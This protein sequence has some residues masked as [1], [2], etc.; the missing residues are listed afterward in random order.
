MIETWVV[1]AGLTLKVIFLSIRVARLEK[2]L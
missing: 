1:I 2:R